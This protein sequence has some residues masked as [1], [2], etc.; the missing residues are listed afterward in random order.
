MTQ[1]VLIFAFNNEQT[2][3]LSMAE[4]SAHNVRR[5]LNLPTSV[6][7]NVEYAGTAFDH[8]IQAD[9]ESG[10]TRYFED[11]DNTVTWH[12][13]G[14][15]DAYTLTPY[16]QTI[17]LDA[18]YVVASTSLKKLLNAQQD[19]MCHK[20]AFDMSAQ[21]DMRSLNTFGRYSMPMWWA[22]VMMFRRS[23]T[24]Q[25]IFDCM[26]MVRDNWQHYRDLYNIDRATY[27]NDFALSIALGIVSGHTMKVDEIPWALPSVMPNT[28]LS[29][30]I[31]D[32]FMIEYQDSN[33]LRKRMGFRGLDFHAMGK[34]DLGDIVETDRRTR[35]FNSSH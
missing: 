21:T 17:V 5:H 14:R 11:Y 2:D 16:D 25:Y 31:D 4:W 24:A 26:Q 28:Q 22:T 1:G 7:T 9:A 20:T 6:V 3:Y 12:N 13:A 33:Q 19:F 8:V 10:G 30:D 34:K 23:N 27:R 32:S 18:D 15:V 35:L 29:R